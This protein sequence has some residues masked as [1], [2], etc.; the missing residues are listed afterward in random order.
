MPLQFGPIESQLLCVNISILDDSVLEDDEQF[1]VLLETNEPMV[2]LTPSA[3]AVF[4]IDDES[5]WRNSVSVCIQLHQ[6]FTFP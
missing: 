2:T 3:A 4:I 5:M 6:F 1:Q